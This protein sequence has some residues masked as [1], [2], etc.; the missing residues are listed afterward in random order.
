MLSKSSH[1]IK[2]SVLLKG[3]DFSHQVQ[4]GFANSEVAWF[5]S[6]FCVS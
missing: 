2:N 3:E 4:V 1:F 6:D 5:E